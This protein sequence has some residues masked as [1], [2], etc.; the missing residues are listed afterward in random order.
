MPGSGRCAGQCARAVRGGDVAAT[1]H[2]LHLH[3]AARPVADALGV[4][5]GAELVMLAVDG[6]HRAAHALQ[7]L[8]Q[9]VVGKWLR[10]PG[11]DPGRQ[12]PGG[13]VAVVFLQ[14]RQLAGPGEILLGRTNALQGAI[15]HE[16][17][18]GLRDH[19]LALRAV[20]GRHH[21]GHAA[22]HAV[23]QHDEI[24]KAQPL[25]HC[26][27]HGLCLPG[28]KAR[29]QRARI[30]VGLAKAQPVVGQHIAARG[31]GQLLREITPQRH[32]TQRVVQ[33]HDGRAGQGLFAG[34]R[35]LPAPDV[36]A[37]LG[38]GNAG[39]AQGCGDV[40]HA[41][42]RHRKTPCRSAPARQ[43]SCARMPPEGDTVAT[44]R[45]EC[46]SFCL[47]RGSFC[48]PGRAGSSDGERQGS[49]V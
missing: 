1:G 40:G 34:R 27:K 2:D 16:G 29:P 28:H 13:L 35:R 6:Q 14:A 36:D 20:S 43:T 5:Q 25:V 7:R 41:G 49:S 8:V 37:A 21:G 19:R 26:R 15:F 24:P 11:I 44:R 42:G 39:F 48:E 18:G 47:S 9:P 45:A 30:G 31:L 17:L 32:R 33:Q 4:D 46:G 3:R 22:A 23:A 10:Q 38:R 12:H